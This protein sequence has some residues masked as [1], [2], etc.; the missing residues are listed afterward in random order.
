[1]TVPFSGADALRWCEGRLAAEADPGQ[2]AGVAIDARKIESGQLF[3]AIRGEHH[4]A[5]RFIDDALHRGAAGLLVEES[6]LSENSPPADT[7]TIAVTDST[8]ALGALARGHR[9]QFQGPVVAVTGSNGKT[10]T[11]ELIHSILSVSG[12]CLKNPGNLNNE[13]GLPLSLLARR[14]GHRK[15]VV[16]LGMN[17]RGEIARLTTIARPDVGVITNIGSAHIEFLGSQEEIAAEKGDLVA[18]LAPGA[19]AILNHDD[20]LVMSQAPR[21]PGPLRTFGRETGAD[22]R[23]ES[24]QAGQD[25]R[26]RFRLVTPE[27]SVQI[28]VS[29]LADTI[30]INALAASAA[31]LVA[32]SDLDEVALGLENFQGVAGRMVGRTMPGGGRLI[33]DT[34]N[35]NPQSMRSALENLVRLGADGRCLAVLG[36][37]GELG[38]ASEESH[39]TL[40]RLAAALGIHQLFLLGENAH[41][42]A[43]DAVAGGM[44]ED[45]IHVEKEQE[46]IGRS[47]QKF[48]QLGD[49]VLVKGSRAMHMERLV[50]ILASEENN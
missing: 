7:C 1:M 29:G 48:T 37:M 47:V 8:E 31:S 38:D 49:W 5:H 9:E 39:R 4:D 45:S 10:T 16:E 18:G 35:A 36:D 3:V 15:A 32:G 17:H 34:Y 20:R 25:G 21:V 12:P 11:K 22:V 43:E 40:G 27:G 14:E 24:V 42:V 13:F 19:T 6:W 2:F 28:R 26:Y 46:S 30:V 41:W 44:R 50:E 33:D 23:A